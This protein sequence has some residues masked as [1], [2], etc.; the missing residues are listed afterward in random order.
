MLPRSARLLAILAASVVISITLVDSPDAAVGGAGINYN[1]R[2]QAVSFDGR[3]T[4]GTPISVDEPDFDEFNESV[5]V[6]DDPNEGRSARGQAGQETTVSAEDVKS[7]TVDADGVAHAEWTDGAAGDEF[8]PEAFGKSEFSLTFTAATTISFSLTGNIHAASSANNGDCGQAKVVVP[9]GQVLEV[10]SPNTGCGGQPDDLD[11]D[12]SG[13]LTPGPHTF[14]VFALASA[15]N[16]N[17][18]GGSA[19]ASFTISLRIGCAVPGAP[20]ADDDNDGDNIPNSVEESIG[21]DPDCRDTDSDGLLDSWEVD[22]DVTGSGFDIDEDGQAD[23]GRDIVFG[24][25]NGECAN[26]FGLRRQPLGQNCGLVF[27]PDPL[28]KDIYV[29]I[30]WQDCLVGSCP[31]FMGAAADPSHHAP[32][33]AGLLNVVNTFRDAPIDNPDDSPGINLHFLVD[34]G[35]RHDHNCDQGAAETR[36]TNFGTAQQ[37]TDPEVLAAKEMSFRYAWSGHSSLKANP[38]DCPLPPFSEIMEA[39]AG[40]GPLPEYDISPH[41][42]AAP[43]GRD[44]LVTLAVTWICQ[45]YTYDFSPGGYFPPCFRPPVIPF[46][47]GLFPADVKGQNGA[48]DV[49]VTF[50]MHVTLGVAP[51]AG[52]T[53]LWGRTMMNLLGYSL[54]VPAGS[55]GNNPSLSGP[56]GPQ[57]YG[58]WNGISYAP[59]A[60]NGFAA[61]S[62]S[63][64]ANGGFVPIFPDFSL[65]E[66]DG[67]GDGFP[68][69]EDTCP[70]LANPTQADLDNDGFGDG[71]DADDD[72]DGIPDANDAAPRDTDND[73]TDNE[74]D[75]EEDGDGVLD[76]G[77]NCTLIP[78]PGQLNTDGDGEGDDCDADDDGDGLPDWIETMMGSNTLSGGSTPEFL[79]IGE[80]CSDSQDNDGDGDT[81]L[82]DNG[83]TDPDGDTVPD[84]VDNCPGVA[85]VNILDSDGDGPGN[86]CDTPSARGDANCSGL[87]DGGDALN[88]LAHLAGIG[89][90]GGVCPAVAAGDPPLGDVNCDDIVDVN[91]VVAALRLAGRLEADLPADCQPHLG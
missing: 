62:L 4:P 70:G 83:C 42:F 38:A 10:N 73:G 47:P 1:A 20:G 66:Q 5:T 55:I 89:T 85:S 25:Y 69:G 39:G 9:D 82:A 13:E 56:L 16:A 3:G 72:A 44:I 37:R 75:G 28:H 76:A 87:P 8:A 68:E 36:P 12:V 7:I 51:S 60:T 15:E 46:P 61:A 11:I 14:S 84:L 24:P 35:I 29:E 86:P 57:S 27:P 80:S 21:T 30:D 17:A 19:D 40:I 2:V 41:G 22:E 18:A 34:E 71:C 79:G 74:T 49:P 88:I 81:D 58:S 23:V 26:S 65:A 45:L 64:G 63:A 50:P 78:N 31:E 48:P 52:V 33:M 59:P 6:F 32:D 67:D 53:Q 90:G 77:D 43:G 54:G 91:D